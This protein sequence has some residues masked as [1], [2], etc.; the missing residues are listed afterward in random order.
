MRD[1]FIEIDPEYAELYRANAQSY[2]DELTLLDLD[3]RAQ[4]V[5]CARP[6]VVVAHD[7]FN[8]LAERYGFAVYAVS[9]I[10]PEA[11]PTPSDLAEL[12]ELINEHD[13]EV[14]FFEETAADEIAQVLADET[15]TTAQVLYTIE[16]IPSDETYLSLMQ[17]NLNKL[18]DAMLCQ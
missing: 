1:A 12:A 14:V 10:S 6:E 13:L 2:I 11:E 7:A 8:Y 5:E 17:A 18:A 4:L 16:I 9:G 15:G 3:Y